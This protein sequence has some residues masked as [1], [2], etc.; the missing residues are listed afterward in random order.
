MRQLVTIACATALLAAALGAPAASAAPPLKQ[1]STAGGL[2][3]GPFYADQL[4]ARVVSCADARRFVT[5]W[6][7][8]REC[9][10]PSGGPSDRVCRVGAYRCVYFDIGYETGRERCRRRGTRRAVSFRFGS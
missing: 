3:A 4:R 9:I 2:R 10:M 1:C 5:R 6:G 8:T 7:N